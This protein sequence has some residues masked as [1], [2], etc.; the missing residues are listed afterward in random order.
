M[1]YLAI[2]LFIVLFAFGKESLGWSDPDGYVQLSLLAAF[3]C[4]IIC[5][6]KAKG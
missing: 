6:Y 1:A 3:L 4:G 2:V 5:G